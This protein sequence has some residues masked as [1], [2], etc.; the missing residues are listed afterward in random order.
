MDPETVAAR[1]QRA[2]GTSE[3]NDEE[4]GFEAETA[5]DPNYC[6]SCYGSEQTPEQCCNT[7]DEVRE[8][9][10][11]KGWAFS[12]P[13]GIEQCEKE[14]FSDNLRLQERRGVQDLRLAGRE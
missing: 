13:D 9:Y 4:D 5:N 10:R 14:G 2:K 1:K 12:D 11:L 3:A 6:G 8:A 7:C